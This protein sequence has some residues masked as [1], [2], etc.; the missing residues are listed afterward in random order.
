MN[1]NPVLFHPL[2]LPLIVTISYLIVGILTLLTLSI[3]K[4]K[5]EKIQ[6]EEYA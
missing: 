2:G 4:I 5:V 6:Q 1:C 3:L